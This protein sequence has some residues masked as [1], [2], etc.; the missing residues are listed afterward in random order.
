MARRWE[1]FFPALPGPV[2][3]RKRVLDGSSITTREKRPELPP[4]KN[5]RLHWRVRAKLTAQWRE[6]A[7]LRA[8]AAEIPQLARVRI[9]AVIHRR[10]VGRAD[11]DNDRA[12]LTALTDGLKLAGVMPDDRRKY[13]EYGSVTEQAWDARGLGITIIVEELPDEHGTVLRQD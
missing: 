2:R 9:S 13:V 4:T 1:L 8:K 5:D 11:E 12:R 10:V 7:Y 3:K 6:A